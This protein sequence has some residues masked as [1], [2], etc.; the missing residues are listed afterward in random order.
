MISNKVNEI[1]KTN[2]IV[3]TNETNEINRINRIKENRSSQQKLCSRSILFQ[4]Q[5]LLFRN[6]YIE[7]TKAKFSIFYLCI[8][9]IKRTKGSEEHLCIKLLGLFLKTRF[10]KFTI[11][12]NFADS[13]NLSRSNTF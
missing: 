3:K 5:F 8:K 4:K 2:E 12:S 1:N 7:K 9:K 11:S 13:Q 6:I 10:A